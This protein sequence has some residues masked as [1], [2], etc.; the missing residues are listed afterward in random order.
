VHGTDD[1]GP[2]LEYTIGSAGGHVDT[3][4]NPGD[5]R[6]PA[7]FEAFSLEVETGLL[8]VSVFT[9]RPNGS[10]EITSPVAIP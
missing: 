1:G 7:T 4:P 5:I 2:S 10:V 8:H 9:V 3:E 6:H